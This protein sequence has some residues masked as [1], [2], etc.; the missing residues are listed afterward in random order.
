MQRLPLIFPWSRRYAHQTLFYSCCSVP[1][2]IRVCC[3]CVPFPDN[4]VEKGSIFVM[5]VV[6]QTNSLAVEIVIQ[7]SCSTDFMVLR[8]DFFF[9]CYV[10]NSHDLVRFL[11][12]SNDVCIIEVLMACMPCVRLDAHAHRTGSWGLTCPIHSSHWAATKDSIF[13][14][15]T[16][17]M[18]RVFT[19]SIALDK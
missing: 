9:L 3:V 8:R 12:Q 19:F 2:I 4:L 16:A 17:G 11:K 5:G 6:I 7:L 1:P 15:L 10:F 14:R 13:S 18:I